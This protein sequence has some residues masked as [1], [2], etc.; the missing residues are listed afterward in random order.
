MHRVRARGVLSR[1]LAVAIVAT[2]GL[3]A[4][5]AAPAMASPAPI[6]LGFIGDITG[7]N[8]SVYGDTGAAAQ[9]RIDLQNAEG[10]VDGHKL[11]LIVEDTQSSPTVAQTAASLLVSKHV[12]GISLVTAFGTL[13]DKVVNQAGLPE[14]GSTL[15]AAYG[16]A[17]FRNWF[18]P[19]IPSNVG[20][21][22][23]VIPTYML[24]FYRSQ[25]TTRWADLAWGGIPSIADSAIAWAKVA[26]RL[27]ISVCVLDDSVPIGTT[28]FTS[29]VLLMKQKHCNAANGSWSDA[30]SVG[31]QQSLKNG[32]MGN[33]VDLQPTGY[34][35]QIL[36]SAP[37]RASLTGAYLES[38]VNFTTPNA[39]TKAMLQGLAKYMPGFQPGD[40]PDDGAQQAWEAVDLMI[41]GLEHAGKNPTAKSFIDTLRNTTVNYTAGGILASP[42]NYTHFGTDKEVPPTS[43]GY[44]LKLEPKGYV[45]VG[46]NGGKYCGPDYVIQNGS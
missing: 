21:N 1:G 4:V 11:K 36:K 26:P 35:S 3:V 22:K 23:T 13:A 14:T 15:D 29:V 34:D 46:P 28:D 25:G 44:V 40:L 6:T 38:Q 31:F 32:G 41:F 5:N 33:V 45:P 39:A 17:P 24:S 42:I 16:S 20:V 27:G 12:F 37:A 9:A 7:L 10:G 19:S 30:S 8:S 2:A 18:T 43:C